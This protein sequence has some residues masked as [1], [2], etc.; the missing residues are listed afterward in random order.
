MAATLL[1]M[2]ARDRA[3]LLR[4]EG[5]RRGRHADGGE[6]SEGRGHRRRLD[7]H[8]RAGVRALARA[9]A[10]RD[11]R[12]RRCTT[13]TPSGARS[14]AASRGGCSNGRGSPGG[15]CSPATSTARST[16]PT[17]SCSR[18]ASAARRRGSRTRRCRCACGCIGQETTGAG[19]FAKAMRTVPVVLDIAE[20]CPRAAAPDAWIVDFTNPVGIVTRALLDAGHRAVGPLQRGD[21]LPAHAAPSCWA[22]SPDA[23][24]GRPGRPQPPDLGARGA[25]RRRGRARPRCW[26][27][28]ASSSPTRRGC[29]AGCST[30]SARSPRTTCTTSTSTT[31]CSPSSATG[32]AAGRRWSPRSS[33]S[34]CELYRDPALT[35]KPA[36]L[37]QRGG[38]F[39]SE[40]A[41]ELVGSLCGRRRRRRRW[42]TSATAARSPASP[43]TTSSRFRRGSGRDGPVPLE[44][45]PLAPELLG[46]RPARRRLR[47]ARRRGGGDA[48]PRAPPRKALLAHP[49]IGQ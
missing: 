26:P 14:S 30:S 34:C 36:L 39:Y 8:A 19:G 33:A 5:V 17:S 22:S 47:A 38:A 12:A 20:R 44:Q 25:A 32:D 40:A 3:V 13:S 46:P 23:A 24:G 42:S 31:R 7:L 11:R 21:R 6:G 4:P 1:F 29:R 18:S 35:E 9:R 48:R 49:L 28:T 16:A 37:E 27:S 41:A 2:A 10:D 15:S 45:A 43:T